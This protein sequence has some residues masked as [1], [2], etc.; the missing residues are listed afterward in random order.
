MAAS[1]MTPPL[2]MITCQYRSPNM[3]RL[4]PSK[5]MNNAPSQCAG[6]AAA[7]AEQTRAADHR[8]A[9]AVQQ[10][11]ILHQL[12]RSGIQAEPC[13]TPQPRRRRTRWP[14]MRIP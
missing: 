11:F 7:A 12:R 4:L 9:D 6:D 13:T 5:A 2:T 3:L 14:H 1:R 8:C 10:D